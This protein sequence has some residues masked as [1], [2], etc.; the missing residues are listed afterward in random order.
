MKSAHVPQGPPRPS[1]HQLRAAF[2]A[3]R[4]T[5]ISAAQESPGGV[6][7]R[8]SSLLTV[9]A[10]LYVNDELQRAWVDGYQ[11]L[12]G[13]PPKVELMKYAADAVDEPGFLEALKALP[14]VELERFLDEQDP[15]VR[16]VFERALGMGEGR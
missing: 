14:S 6:T 9:A 8:E 15:D 5:G 3:G 2:D 1:Q 12:V 16:D 7:P 4:A 10:L 13:G 11:F